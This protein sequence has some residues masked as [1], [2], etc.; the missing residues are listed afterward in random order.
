MQTTQKINLKDFFKKLNNLVI[1]ILGD[2]GGL[3]KTLL[4]Y[5]LTSRIQMEEPSVQLI[6]CDNDQHSSGDFALIRKDAGVKPDMPVV[7]INTKNLEPYLLESSK[8]IKVSLIEFGK[9]FG[10]SE[11]EKDKNRRNALEL[12]VKLGDI[13]LYPMPASPIDAVATEKWEKE[14][15]KEIQ[16][17]PAIL[18]P[19]R[20]KSKARL[21]MV[22]NSAPDIKYF[23]ITDSY[24]SDRL[25]FQ[26][27]FMK[28][29]RSIFEI[30][31]RN[32]SEREGIAEFESVFQEIINI[33][34]EFY[35]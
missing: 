32:K 27:S 35:G 17:M 5:N 14:L 13:I 2:K 8:K 9:S 20:V 25:C 1:V 4:G 3:G 23:K 16:N 19:N 22:L 30:N 29:G 18:I 10:E 12:A 24:L 6:D 15:P 31:P 34:V 21:K 11:A 28:N 33:L 26:D 7:K